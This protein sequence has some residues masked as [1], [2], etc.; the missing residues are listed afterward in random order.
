VVVTITVHPEL[1]CYIQCNAQMLIVGIVLASLI[2]MA[3][4]VSDTVKLVSQSHSII[5]DQ[6][7][8]GADNN[9]TQIT[10]VSI[11]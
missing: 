9:E 5:Y 3:L 2:T 7:E 11:H 4:S 8:V 6:S 10:L 1:N